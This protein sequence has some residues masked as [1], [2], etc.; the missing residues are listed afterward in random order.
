VVERPYSIALAPGE[1]ELERARFPRQFI[2]FWVA[3]RPATRRPGGSRS[4]AS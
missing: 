4:T 2:L 1:P 3:P